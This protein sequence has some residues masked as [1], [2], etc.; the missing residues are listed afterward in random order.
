MNPVFA[1]LLPVLVAIAGP[2]PAASFDCTKAATPVEKQVCADPELGALDERLAA[3]FKALGDEQTGNERGRRAPRSDDQR[4]WLR[5]VR[6][7]CADAA[8][9]RKAYADRIAVLAAWHQPAKA[10]ATIAG[11]YSVATE[12]GVVAGAGTE[13]FA[14][15]DCLSIVP[16]DDGAF[17]VAI[18]SVQTNV[19]TCAFRGQA[20]AEGNAFRG[21]PGSGGEDPALDEGEAPCNVS[22]LVERGELRIQ[23]EGTCTFHC[24]A[25]AHLDGLVYV[26]DSRAP[27][28]PVACPD[29]YADQ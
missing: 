21:I 12:V 27:G 14:T 7:R 20:R 2:A 13:T 29:P 16:R 6:D 5:E 4:R 8:C 28:P 23:A 26:R 25:R 24:G 1:C 9:L 22:V 17:D 3:A 19:H 10:D 18:E 15:S 11:Q